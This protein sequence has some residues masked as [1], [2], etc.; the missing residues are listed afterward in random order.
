MKRFLVL[1]LVFTTPAFS[2]ELSGNWQLSKIICASGDTPLWSWEPWRI[3]LKFEA[4]NYYTIIRQ[5]E[6]FTSFETGEYFAGDVNQFCFK[7]DFNSEW[8]AKCYDVLLEDRVLR[9]GEYMQSDVGVQ[10]E[11]VVILRVLDLTEGRR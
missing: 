8:P 9:L 10:T 4:P 3:L 7:N 2:A 5:R 6:E 1:I 11:L